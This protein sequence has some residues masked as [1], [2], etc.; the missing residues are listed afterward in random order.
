M[1][2]I[3]SK[4]DLG[5]WN[6]DVARP[7]LAL[8]PPANTGSNTS[9]KQTSKPSTRERSRVAHRRFRP[10]EATAAAWSMTEGAAKIPR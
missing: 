9:T 7:K 8:P 4:T 2:P 3:S 10:T 6:Q 1:L 5:S